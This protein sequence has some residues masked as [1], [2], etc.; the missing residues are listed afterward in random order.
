LVENKLPTDKFVENKLLI[1]ALP[2]DILVVWNCPE[3]K[4]NE[5][6]L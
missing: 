2:T 1:V 6:I 3:E 5:L 4:F